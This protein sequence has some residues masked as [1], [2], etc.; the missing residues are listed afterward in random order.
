MYPFLRRYGEG[1][2]EELPFEGLRVFDVLSHA[3]SAYFVVACWITH[4]LFPARPC[5]DLDYELAC[6]ALH[7]VAFS[8]V[9][10]LSVVLIAGLAVVWFSCIRSHLTRHPD[11]NPRPHGSLGQAMSGGQEGGDALYRETESPSLPGSRLHN[12]QV[13][14]RGK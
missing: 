12:L 8:F 10:W 5:P 13:R 9:I 6:R 11:Q 4:A 1:Q 14:K 7:T 3:A 2:T